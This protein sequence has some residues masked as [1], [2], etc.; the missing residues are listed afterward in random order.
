MEVR[1]SKKKVNVRTRMKNDTKK[2][3]MKWLHTQ[4]SRIYCSNRVWG[5]EIRRGD[6]KDTSSP[7]SKKFW[8]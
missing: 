3:K 8:R 1:N 7:E 4:T 5:E 6:I 2:I